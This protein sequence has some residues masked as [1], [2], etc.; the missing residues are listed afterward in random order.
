MRRPERFGGA[1]GVTL[2]LLLE[3]LFSALLA[4]IRMLFHTQFVLAA[5]TGLGVHWNSPAREDAETTWS[6]ALRRHGV[7]TLVGVA[8]AAGVYWLD[9][10]YL[11]WLAPVV[12][13]LALSI[14]VSV[15]SSRV[16][17]GRALRRAR[18]FL[19]PEET[20][21]PP[22]LRAL[23]AYRDRAG[24]PPGSSTRWWIRSSTRSPA[25]RRFRRRGAPPA[26]WRA[27]RNWSPRR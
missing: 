1:L 13:A 19:I 7:H 22:E 21:P 24:A 27:A 17:L 9:P 5:L 23:R 14:P 16:S 18:L 3:L 6:E 10:A 25:R 11:W 26:R 2:S 8:W 20:D 12:G 4:P 15:Y